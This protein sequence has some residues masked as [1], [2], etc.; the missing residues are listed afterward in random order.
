MRNLL[1][2]SLALLGGCSTGIVPTDA[3]TYMSS[4]TSPGGATV[5]GAAVLADLYIEANA[6]CAK[7]SKVVETI[8]KT[9]VNGQ[10][11]VRPSSAS[12]RFRCTLSRDE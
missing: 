5:S 3:G 8:E 10:V 1:L 7:Q 12:L 4:R 2:A 9:V 11:F 6:F